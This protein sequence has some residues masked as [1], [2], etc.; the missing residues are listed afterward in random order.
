MVLYK[1]VLYKK[2]LSVYDGSVRGTS[3]NNEHAPTKEDIKLTT[4]SD[5]SCESKGFFISPTQDIKQ[6][7]QLLFTPTANDV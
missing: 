1:G 2:E 6:T 7:L 3:K 4:L 5:S